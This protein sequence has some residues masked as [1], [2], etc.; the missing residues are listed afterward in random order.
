MSECMKV[1]QEDGRCQEEKRYI[2]MQSSKELKE[3]KGQ[4]IK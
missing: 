4:P 3:E 1:A 2:R